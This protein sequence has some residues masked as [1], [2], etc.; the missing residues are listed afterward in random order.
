[1]YR[2]RAIDRR[3]GYHRIYGEITKHASDASVLNVTIFH[4][5]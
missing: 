2:M 4:Q 3:P 5:T 1:M